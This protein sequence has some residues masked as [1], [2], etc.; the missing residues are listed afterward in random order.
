MP[1]CITVSCNLDNQKLCSFMQSVGRVCEE[2]GICNY[3][4]REWG[5]GA[6]LEHEMPSPASHPQRC[7]SDIPLSQFLGP[8][9]PLQRP[10]QRRTRRRGPSDPDQRVL[11][12]PPGA[13][14]GVGGRPQ[15]RRK[16]GRWF[17]LEVASDA[18][19][20]CFP[21]CRNR[22]KAVFLLPLSAKLQKLLGRRA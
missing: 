17:S 22:Q 2:G 7:L 12:W 15:L 20:G 1:L 5:S 18:P 10:G 4:T 13:E 6:S 11:T 9:K 19:A 3:A 21:Q 8:S 14:R 16:V